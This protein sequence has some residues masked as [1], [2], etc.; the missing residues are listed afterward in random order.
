MQKRYIIVALVIVV[1]GILIWKLSSSYA[2]VNQG[3]EGNKIVSGNNW[4]MNIINVSEPTLEGDAIL[5]KNISTIATTL[6]FEVSLPNPDS[7]ISFDFEIENMGKLDAELCAMT[8]MGLSTVQSEYVDYIIEPLDYVTVKTE[9]QAG[10]ILK[11]NERHAFRITVSYQD[12][13]NEKNILN[14]VLNLGSTI[15]Y[16]QK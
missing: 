7:K 6:A 8:L 5:V 12:N 11:T 4:S 1:V 10:S 2:L 3:F 14:Q 16:S 13:V 15:I 9:T